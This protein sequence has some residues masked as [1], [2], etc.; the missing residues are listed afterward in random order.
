MRTAEARIEPHILLVEA[1]NPP[2]KRVSLLLHNRDQV[3][4]QARLG[5][6]GP[7]SCKRGGWGEHSSRE[8]D[9]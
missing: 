2:L 3:P 7:T 6:S 5:D 4:G 9:E 1:P 8:D